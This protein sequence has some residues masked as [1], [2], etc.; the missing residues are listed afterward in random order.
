MDSIF[1]IVMRDINRVAPTT[2]GHIIGM[3]DIIFQYAW[4]KT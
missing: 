4:Y 3:L 1:L 2:I